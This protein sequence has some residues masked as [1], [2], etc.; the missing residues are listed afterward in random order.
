MT[1]TFGTLT[2]GLILAL[3]LTQRAAASQAMGVTS[4]RS[5][6]PWLVAL[7][8]Q[9]SERSQ[10]FRGLVETINA[11]DGIV[12]VEEGPCGHGVRAC[13]VS[14]T[15]AGPNRFLWVR[16][17]THKADWDLMGDIGHE[18]RHTIEVLSDPTIRSDTKMYLF[19]ALNG[20][21]RSH[22]AHAFETD[23]ATEA[24]LAVRSEVR[25]R[26]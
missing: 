10:T 14:V 24:G 2:V 7:I 1:K 18:L 19:Y 22:G 17:D 21:N 3:G 15:A 12:Y 5:S 20:P 11:S 4:V 23:A 13:F 6:S 16:V 9:A 26:Y 25:Q 8:E